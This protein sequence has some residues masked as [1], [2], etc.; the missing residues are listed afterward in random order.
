[1]DADAIGEASVAAHTGFDDPFAEIL[2]ASL[3]PFT[4]QAAPALPADP[5]PSAEV[6]VHDERPLPRD[7]PNDLVTVPTTS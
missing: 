2:V 4:L 1:V 6:E 7:R 3:T 5:D